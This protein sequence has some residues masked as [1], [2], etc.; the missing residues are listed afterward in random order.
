MDLFKHGKYSIYRPKQA[1]DRTDTINRVYE[2]AADYQAN[3]Q[4]QLR[5][6]DRTRSYSVHKPTGRRGSFDIIHGHENLTTG[7]GFE[8]V[9]GHYS[10]PENK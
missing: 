6:G 5:G 2:T 4:N 1:A 8:R 7:N 3:Q 9:V 10:P